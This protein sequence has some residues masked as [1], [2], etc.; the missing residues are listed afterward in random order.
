MSPSFCV[1]SFHSFLHS[2]S[3][4]LL[5]AYYVPGNVMRVSRGKRETVLAFMK[6]IFLEGKKQRR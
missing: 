2:S 5:K 1:P 3:K 6:L 4:Y